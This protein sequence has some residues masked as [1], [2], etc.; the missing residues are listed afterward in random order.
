MNESVSRRRPFN[1]AIIRS[2][3]ASAIEELHKLE[4]KAASGAL[5]EDELQVG[6]NHAYH[7]LNFAWNIR[8]ISTSEYARLTQDQFEQWGKYPTEINDL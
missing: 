4:Q 7:H 8:R 6:L 1:R 3:I 5:T 2:D